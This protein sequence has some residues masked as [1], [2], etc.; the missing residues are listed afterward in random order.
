LGKEL[1]AA[2]AKDAVERTLLRDRDTNV[3]DLRHLHRV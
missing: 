2:L 1:G 3:A